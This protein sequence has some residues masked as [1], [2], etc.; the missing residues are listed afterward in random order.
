MALTPRTSWTRK[1]TKIE[2]KMEGAME[3]EHIVCNKNLAVQSASSVQAWGIIDV[4]T[5]V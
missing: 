4:E 3:K 1:T 2:L 5:K